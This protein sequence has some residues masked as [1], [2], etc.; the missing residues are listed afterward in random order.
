VCW[1]SRHI[2]PNEHCDYHMHLFSGFARAVVVLALLMPFNSGLA[3][4]FEPAQ[5]SYTETYPVP[6]GTTSAASGGRLGYPHVS[7]SGRLTVKSCCGFSTN[8]I[9]FGISNEVFGSKNFGIIVGSFDFEWDT[10]NY[11]EYSMGFS[12]KFDPGSPSYHDKIVE[13]SVTEVGPPGSINTYLV[14]ESVA[15]GAVAATAIAV[16]LV[17][18]LLRRGKRRAETHDH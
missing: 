15:V 12:N 8:D 18:V 17:F 11:S 10:G 4:W 3:S 16:S 6:A 13:I 9:M 14:L 7:V 1:G 2:K 5:T